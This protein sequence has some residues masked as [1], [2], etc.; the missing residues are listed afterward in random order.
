[1]SSGY[2]A[3]LA[4][5]L[6]HPDLV[7]GEHHGDQDG[8]RPDRGL[9]VIQIDQPLVI[10]A[11]PGHFTAQPFDMTAAV[12]HRLVFGSHRNHMIPFGGIGFE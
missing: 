6:D 10:D 4:D 7:V 3:D 5:R 2:R 11:Q 8:R 1:M 9:E 12:Q